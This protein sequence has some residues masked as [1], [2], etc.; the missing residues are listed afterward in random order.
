MH[1]CRAALEARLKPTTEVATCCSLLISRETPKSASFSLPVV[2]NNTSVE[3]PSQ[4]SAVVV[5][6]IYT[7]LSGLYSDARLLLKAEHTRT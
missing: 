2:A 7:L 1:V 3:H 5:V 6:A 4:T